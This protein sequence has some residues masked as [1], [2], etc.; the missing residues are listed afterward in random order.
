VLHWQSV[1]PVPRIRVDFGD[2]RRIE[3]TVTG[4]SIHYV[5]DADGAVI[6]ALPGLRGAESFDSSLRAALEIAEKGRGLRVADRTE[7]YANAHR[8][9]L[10]TL[11]ARW[12]ADLTKLGVDAFTFSVVRNGFSDVCDS[13]GE[14]MG[15]SQTDDVWRKIAELHRSEARLDA[16]SR[17]LL[18]AKNPTAEEAGVRSLSKHVV[19]SPL[20][21]AMRNLESSIALDSVRNEFLLHARIHQWLIENPDSARDV[22][23]FNRRVYAELF[24]TPDNDPWLGLAPADTLSAL[25]D[26]GL[27]THSAR[28]VTNEE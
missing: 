15:R 9:A 14:S 11:E 10:T 8:R 27:V 1:R 20:L 19:E 16:S 4:N 3:R 18:H 26:E 2:G 22:E 21:R 24:L 6:D 25:D 17:A 13:P 7:L 23:K 12:N 5:L 28:S